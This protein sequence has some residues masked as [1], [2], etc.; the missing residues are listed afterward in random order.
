MLANHMFYKGVIFR[1]YNELVQLNN[2][3]IIQ[4]KNG[5]RI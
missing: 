5:Q 2:K 4:L 3:K 1:I